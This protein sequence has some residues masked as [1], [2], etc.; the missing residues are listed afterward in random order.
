[1]EFSTETLV[2][3]LRDS[4][5]VQ[6]PSTAEDPIWLQMSDDDLAIVLEVAKH[7]DFPNQVLSSLANGVVYPLML[8]AKKELYYRLAVK[9]APNY[10]IRGDE[11]GELKRSQ[12]FEHFMSLI[13]QTEAE[14][15]NYME[16]GY[17]GEDGIGDL[18][19]G[20]ASRNK[21]YVRE[22]LITS[23]YYT[24]RNY[25]LLKAPSVGVFIDSLDSSRVQ[26]HWSVT[27]THA[28]LRY[29]VYISENEV[30]YDE[31][32][33]QIDPDAT[34][35]FSSTDQRR[36]SCEIDELT[37]SKRYHVLVE[38]CECN[39]IK[40]YG[41]VVFETSTPITDTETDTDTDTETDTNTET[42]TEGE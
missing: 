18:E 4:V 6:D 20:T 12:R 26:L 41:G 35:V 38:V 3:Y 10:D 19:D 36:M 29:N 31:Y 14:L 1:M 9:T 32:K 21:V 22:A 34:L 16:N 30:I 13:K 2:K 33:H 11:A 8:V 7:R 5:L 39:G 15:Q 42:E 40:G 17:F 37:A 28:F 24:R 23:R 25:G 27:G